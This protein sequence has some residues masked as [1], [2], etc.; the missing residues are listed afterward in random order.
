MTTK[1]T[2]APWHIDKTGAVFNPSR[3]CA[4]GDMQFD[5]AIDELLALSA[6]ELLETLQWVL[7]AWGCQYSIEEASVTYSDARALIAKITQ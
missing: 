3:N 1:H 2:P 7:D 4:I 5:K 6:P